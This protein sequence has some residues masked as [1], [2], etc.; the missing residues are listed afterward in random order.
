MQT[1]GKL[2]NLQ[3]FPQGLKGIMLSS[4]P[5]FFGHF[6]HDE[7]NGYLGFDRISLAKNGCGVWLPCNHF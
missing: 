7:Q 6:N 1:I 4:E 3:P 5:K 2:Q